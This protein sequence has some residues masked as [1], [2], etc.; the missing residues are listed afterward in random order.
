MGKVIDK[1]LLTPDSEISLGGLSLSFVGKSKAYTPTSRAPSEPETGDAG[2][3]AGTIRREQVRRSTRP[4]ATGA[5][6]GPV[7]D[8]SRQRRSTRATMTSIP[9]SSNPQ[10]MPGPDMSAQS[11]R[12]LVP[13][14]RIFVDVTAYWGNDDA[15]ST[16]RVSRRRWKA[17]LDGASYTTAAWS[18]YE[19]KRYPVT[20]RFASGEVSIDGEDGRQCA[21][22]DPVS[23]LFVRVPDDAG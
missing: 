20:W 13:K 6:Q 9:P 23:S 17:I 21:V 15:E 10:L 14:R 4:R 8:S 22:D 11:N 16:I 2:I 1:G 7:R 19:G 3:G 12:K 18:W 5:P